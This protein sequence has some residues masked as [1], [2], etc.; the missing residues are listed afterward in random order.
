MFNW[1]KRHFIPHEGNNHRP[2]FLHRH[3]AKQL[4][5]VVLLFELVLFILP[6]VNFVGF[7][8]TLNLGAVLPS[9]LSNLTND[10][11]VSKNLPL[12]TENALLNEAARLKAEDMAAKGYFAHT[13]PEGLSPWYWID[14]VGYAYDYAGENLAVNFVDSQ[15]VTEAWMNSPG[16]RANIVHGAYTEVG[17]GIATGMYKG[18]ET[19]FVAQVY[20]HPVR[21]NTSIASFVETAPLPKPTGA[22]SQVLAL[23]QTPVVSTTT[24]VS[25]A[26]LGESEA[27]PAPT[28][29]PANVNRITQEAI[30]EFFQGAAASP[31]HAANAVFYSVMSIITLALL[32]NIFIKI[33]H[34]HPDLILNGAVVMVVV[35]GL[36]LTNGYISREQA[37]RTSFMAYDSQTQVLNQE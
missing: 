17:T 7:V 35:L 33:R 32:F 9:M 27:E 15:D 30:K 24:N 23:N 4:I 20:A 1:L 3:N 6:S 10:E 12:L 34:Q 29:K 14:K 21:I 28:P 13:S 37:I 16:H 8:G 22:G 36:H 26:V 18:Y 19:I 25:T 5:G 11:R 2:H 31:R